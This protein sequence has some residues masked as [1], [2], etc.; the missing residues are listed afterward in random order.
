MNVSQ[1][2]VRYAKAFYQLGEEKKL[3]DNF[4]RDVKLLRDSVDQTPDFKRFFFNPV[5]KPSIKIDVLQQTF[6]GNIEDN[7]LKFLILIVENKREIFLDD[8]IRSFIDI[9]RQNNNINSVTISA[10]KELSKKNIDLIRKK[11][12]EKN[13]S[14]AE[15]YTKVNPNLIGGIILR[16][17]DIQ[18]DSTVKT[19]LDKYRK[20]LLNTAI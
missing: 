17:D 6:K 12:E 19:A 2:G 5:I 8:I 9:Y 7:T 11:I 20:E 14:S 3:V 10:A 16:I 1:I 13:K 15:V 18:Y 4:Y